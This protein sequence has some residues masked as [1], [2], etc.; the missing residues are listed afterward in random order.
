VPITL[1]L[2]P[3]VPP[4]LDALQL[5]LLG[6]IVAH[7]VRWALLVALVVVALGE[8]VAMGERG[9]NAADQVADE[10]NTPPAGNPPVESGTKCAAMHAPLLRRPVAAVTLVVV[11]GAIDQDRYWVDELAPS[12]RGRTR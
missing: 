4:V 11:T 8:A 5:G 7:V 1:T 3:V 6:R 2:V 10:P 9:A 12:Y